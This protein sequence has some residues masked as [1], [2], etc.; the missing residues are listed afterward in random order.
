MNLKKDETLGYWI[1]QWESI[2]LLNKILCIQIILTMWAFH[3]SGFHIQSHKHNEIQFICQLN[4][5]P[6]YLVQNFGVNNYSYD[7]F[8][9]WMVGRFLSVE[10]ALNTIPSQWSF[11]I[12]D[13]V[14]KRPYQIILLPLGLCGHCPLEM[15]DSNMF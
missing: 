2:K 5:F 15:Y 4:L 3:V 10:S 9:W 14:K 12:H 13:G 8:W 7:V 11:G 6:C 1:D